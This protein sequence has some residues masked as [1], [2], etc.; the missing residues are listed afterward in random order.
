MGQFDG[1]LYIL[2]FGYIL[3]EAGQEECDEELLEGKKRR[4]IRTRL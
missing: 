2:V 4:G 3:L 1:M